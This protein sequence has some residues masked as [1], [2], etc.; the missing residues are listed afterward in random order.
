MPPNHVDTL[1]SMD[2]CGLRV[3]Q[4]NARESPAPAS[5]T[6]AESGRPFF[7]G[8]KRGWGGRRRADPAI[9]PLGRALKDRIGE[10]GDVGMHAA[11]VSH[12]AQKDAAIDAGGEGGVS[13][14]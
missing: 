2:L 12:D 1:S 4:G 3:G 6:I 10:R 5:L 8:G 7:F 11:Q 13:A 14:P 9:Y